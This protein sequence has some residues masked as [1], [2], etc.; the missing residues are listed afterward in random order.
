MLRQF[1]WLS[2]AMVG[3]FVCAGHTFA[4]GDPFGD[5]GGAVDDPFGGSDPGASAPPAGGDG[6]AGDA[7]AEA[8]DPDP[9]VRAIRAANPTTPEELARAIRNVVNLGRSDEAKKYARR[10][11]DAAPDRGE[12]VKLHRK[13]GASFFLRLHGD[14]R[15][16][17]E[18]AELGKM[19]LDAAAEAARDPALLEALIRQLGDPA[20]EV[21]HAA[22]VDLRS[23][24]SAS[25][26]ALIKVLAD[27]GRRA[28]HASVRRA[29]VSLRSESVEP[30]LGALGSGDPMLT[31]QAI[32]VLSQL[33]VG[34]AA[35]HFFAP[36]YKA[37]ASSTLHKAAEYGLLRLLGEVPDRTR[38]Q[39]ILARE[40]DQF[41]KG[42]LTGRLDHEDM[43]TV[44]SWDGTQGEPVPQ[45]LPSESASLVVAVRLAGDLHAIDPSNVDHRRLYLMT[46][47]EMTKRQ[48]GLDRPMPIGD[49]TAHAAA[50]ELGA[51]VIADVLDYSISVDRTAAAAGA[52]EVLGDIGGTEFLQ[53]SNGR[54]S[55]LASAMRHKDRR[56]RFAAVE[57]VMKLDPK[58][59]YAG[60]SYLTEALGYFAST[61]GSRRA[62]V[63]HPSTERAQTLVGLLNQLGFEADTAPTGRHAM[64]LAIQNPDYEFVLMSDAVDRPPVGELLQQFRRQPTTSLLPIGVMAR[65]DNARRMDELTYGDRLSLALPRP[66]GLDGVSRT[67]RRVLAPAGMRSVSHVERVTHAVTSLD[68]LTTLA[69]Q[70]AV[71]PFYDLL[72]QEHAIEHAMNMP[73]LNEKTSRLLGLLASPSAQRLLVT[74]AS[75]N[76]RPLN[77]RQA[78]AAAFEV[79]VQRR[80]L[81]LTRDEILQQYDRYN[82][83]AVLDRDT[84]QVLG[85]LLDSI[86]LPTRVEEEQSG[87][88]KA[89]AEGRSE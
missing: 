62:L 3:A 81:L 55:T 28:E 22:L 58:T 76:G 14:Q 5:A 70:A 11:I 24:G 15:F 26:V 47:L 54:P 69:E 1:V 75:Q 8:E 44:W 33:G 59:P 42:K 17:P 77:E 48:N 49:G 37:P 73:F 52:I 2:L 31:A 72:R 35:P 29:L 38:T 34:K 85:S 84:Q 36:Y 68:H 18:G 10:L 79:A 4:Q 12:L 9:V 6:A 13:F 40:V 65:Q 74:F 67:V 20:P 41:L 64:S 50:A 27:E 51:E 57:A 86:E 53:T 60:S 80:G 83:S 61:V 56:V 25:V 87:E 7:T 23:G 89:Q 66:H 82:R 78:A 43:V 32:V 88:P 30:L 16:A 19:V 46:L 21:R 45:H 39:S 71:Y 63:I